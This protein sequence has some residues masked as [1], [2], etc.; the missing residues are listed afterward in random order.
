MLSHDRDVHSVRR[1]RTQ[2]PLGGHY[3]QPWQDGATV[4]ASVDER[5]P[6]A[7][8]PEPCQGNLVGSY[9]CLVASVGADAAMQISAVK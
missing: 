3:L 7:T 2:S 5:A 8:L 4:I 9:N 1:V 6:L